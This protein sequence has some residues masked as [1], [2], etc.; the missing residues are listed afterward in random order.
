MSRTPQLG[1]N[2]V[3]LRPSRA[4][5]QFSAPAAF[6]GSVTTGREQMR[7]AVVDGQLDLLRVDKDE[8]HLFGRSPVK[9]R[10]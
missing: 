9:N 1:E 8:A 6:F 4:T 3:A 2:L 5:A 10:G 7:D